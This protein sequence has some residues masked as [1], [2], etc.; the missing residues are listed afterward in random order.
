M[1][2]FINKG[3]PCSKLEDGGFESR[4]GNLIFSIYFILPASLG[5]EVYSDIKEYQKIFQG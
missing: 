2:E 4:L 5:S 1:N 3:A